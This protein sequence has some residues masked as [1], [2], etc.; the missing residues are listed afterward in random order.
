MYDNIVF[1]KDGIIYDTI[2]QCSKQYICANIMWILSLLEFTYRVIIYILINYPG[3]ERRKIY[4]INGYEKSYLRQ[5]ICMISTEEYND[6]II[7]MNLASIIWDNNWYSKVFLWILHQVVFILK[8]SNR[9]KGWIKAQEN[10]RY[11]Q[12]DKKKILFT[13]KR[14]R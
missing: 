6:K 10:T 13:K 7:R 14:R 5:K 8:Y 3:H 12:N 9:C 1:I 4:G 2:Y 11:F